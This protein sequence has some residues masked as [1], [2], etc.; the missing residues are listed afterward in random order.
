[1]LTFM[2]L[3]SAII[4]QKKGKY[5]LFDYVMELNGTVTSNYNMCILLP[6]SLELQDHRIEYLA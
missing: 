1:M 5:K 4:R 6:P 3:G 2:F